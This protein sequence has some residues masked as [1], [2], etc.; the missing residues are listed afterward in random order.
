M[1][2]P[3]GLALLDGVLTVAD[4]AN[5][6]LIGFS[7]GHLHMDCSAI[8]VAG[9]PTF[10]DKGDNR[11]SFPTRDSLCWPYGIAAAGRTL[12]IA[13]SGNNRVLLWEA[14]S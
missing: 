5:S 2:M 12:A 10:A 9:Q 11:W 3:Y 13:D 7:S 1:N 8:S 14:A 4:T 6:R